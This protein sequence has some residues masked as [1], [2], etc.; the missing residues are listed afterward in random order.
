M[1]EDNVAVVRR[2][3]EAFIRGDFELA[4][5]AFDPAVEYDLT[6][7]VPDGQVLSGPAGVWEG[8]RRWLVA[9]E[10]YRMEVDE[11]LDAGDSVV[12]SFRESGRGKGTGLPVEQSVTG[13]WKL[14]DGKVVRVTPYLDRRQA[15]Q[16]AGLSE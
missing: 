15:L 11:Y 12:V 16:A 3:F 5:A 8:M 1:S 10:D 13:I 14:D 7:I 4:M 6:R 9:W 2:A